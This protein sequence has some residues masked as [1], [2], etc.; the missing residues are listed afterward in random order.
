MALSKETIMRH[1][2]LILLLTTS[3]IFAQI[4]VGTGFNYQ[5][6]LLDNGAPANGD[7]DII[8]NAYT[9]LTGGSQIAT[10]I[11]L[12]DKLINNGLINIE[13]IDLGFNSYFFGNEIWLELTI[14]KSSDPLGSFEVLAPRQRLS[15]VPYAVK[16]EYSD[17]TEFAFRAGTA[18][19]SLDLAI[20]SSIFND[21]LTFDGTNWGAKAP[22]WSQAG[23][24]ELFA[25]DKKVTI[26]AS[27]GLGRLSVASDG[28]E[29]YAF[30]VHADSG[31]EGFFVHQNAGISIGNGIEPP[32]KGVYISGD[33]VQASNR[34]GMMKYMVRV[35]CKNQGSSIILAY[36]NTVQNPLTV[37]DESIA[38]RCTVHFPINI[39]NRY[40]QVTPVATNGTT[41]ANCHTLN[42]NNQLLCQRRD[43]GSPQDGNIMIL[44]Y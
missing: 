42:A 44:V 26:G 22:L 3:N 5:G 14:K 9:N 36:P 29:T 33:V 25:N 20:S 24:D 43:A 23:N 8:I 16:S 11:I 30:N 21:V 31:S 12:S 10:P 37:T 17:N 40:W 1:I 32:A 6:E 34:D 18:E 2:L 15:A 13:K 28:S 4:Q 27:S 35:D 39:N 41:I 7:Y 19:R 38:G